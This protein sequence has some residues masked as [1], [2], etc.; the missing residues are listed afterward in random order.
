MV[1][2]HIVQAAWLV[3]ALLAVSFFAAA[4]TAYLALRPS[5]WLGWAEPVGPSGRILRAL[6]RHRPLVMATLMAGSVA[7]VYLFGYLATTASSVFFPSP[8][9]PLVGL[10]GAA[11][12]LIPLGAALPVI[13][14]ARRPEPVARRLAG[15]VAVLT[16]LLSPLVW[17]LQGLS[18]VILRMGGVSSFDLHP[19]LTEDELKAL[20]AQSERQGALPESQRQMLYGVLDFAGQTVAQVMT[21]RPDMISADAD[22]PLGEALALA[23]EHNHRRLPVYEENDDNIVGVLYLKD[24]LPLPA[25][26]G[27]G[28]ARTRGRPASLLRSR[29]PARQRP[30]AAVPTR[31]PVHR[32]RAR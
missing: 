26:P 25:R 8:W 12:V 15:P 17:L 14:A 1:P 18:R 30:A 32:H 9:A 28:P 10:A 24:V 4:R 23:L 21:P 29:D 22:A 7:T 27:A 5:V 3:A 16:A 20:L 19:P 31:P 2:D 13:A 6:H 11:L